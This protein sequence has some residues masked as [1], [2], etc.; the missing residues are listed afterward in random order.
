MDRVAYPYD[1][2][3]CYKPTEKLSFPAALYLYTQGA[4]Y[5]NKTEHIL[6]Q[7]KPKFKADLTICDD[8]I[9]YD[10]TKLVYTRPSAV[11]VDGVMVYNND[12]TRIVC[13]KNSTINNTTTAT[14]SNTNNNQNT[15]T[16]STSISIPIQQPPII[17]SG[18]FIPGILI[19]LLLTY[20]IYYILC[21]IHILYKYMSIL[22]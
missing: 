2:N 4:A 14:I 11:V 18:P 3:T 10:Y 8:V 19:L 9:L 12:N 15:T 17:M 5:A 6:G 22:V 7:I 20:N 16:T 21:F 13:I 1:T